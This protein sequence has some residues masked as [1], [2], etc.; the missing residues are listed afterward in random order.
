MLYHDCS[1]TIPNMAQVRESILQK[2]TRRQR[3]NLAQSNASASTGQIHSG[4]QRRVCRFFEI[5]LRPR[6]VWFHYLDTRIWSI[7]G[8][9]FNAPIFEPC[10][11]IEWSAGVQ[12][13]FVYPSE[14]AGE[15]PNFGTPR[16]PGPQEENTSLQALH[17]NPQFWCGRQILEEEVGRFKPNLE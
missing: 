12:F 6:R 8:R 15:H 10:Q 9:G 4:Y 16:A 5:H 11:S 7:H 1:V 2:A 13:W 17:Q 14:Y 3:P